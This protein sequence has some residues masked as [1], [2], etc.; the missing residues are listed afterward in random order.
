MLHECLLGEVSFQDLDF[1][2]L[3]KSL[4]LLHVKKYLSPFYVSDVMAFW[5]GDFNA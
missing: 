2:K 1:L 3:L 5:E 4:E